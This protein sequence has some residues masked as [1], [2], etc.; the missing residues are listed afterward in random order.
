MGQNKAFL[1]HPG[2][3]TFLQHAAQR[4]AEVCSA[5][6]ISSQQ[7]IE[8]EHDLIL[9]PIAYRGPAVGIA[10][11]LRF[12]DR[13][14]FAACMFTPVDMPNLTTDDLLKI[15]GDWQQTNRLTVAQADDRLQPLVAVYPVSMLRPIEQ[16]AA[17]E[18]RSLLNWLKSQPYTAVPISRA[19]GHNVN[20]PEDLSDATQLRL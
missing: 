14:S 3:L 16:L 15:K 19:A 4:I 10:A 8:T 6:R 11:S 7:P 9:D 18:D 13:H 1:P 20:T 2:G 17:S 5:V 12:A